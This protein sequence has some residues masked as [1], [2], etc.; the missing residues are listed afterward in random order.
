[1]GKGSLRAKLFTFS[2]GFLG[3]IVLGLVAKE[4]KSK[5]SSQSASLQTREKRRA[6]SKLLFTDNT[7]FVSKIL[8]SLL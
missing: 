5:I 2:S 4:L 8:F 1:M 3:L 6:E 7:D